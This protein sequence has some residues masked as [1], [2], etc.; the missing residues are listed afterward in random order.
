MKVTSI[1]IST[2]SLAALGSAR[3]LNK[4]R[5]VPTP[6]AFAHTAPTGQAFEL[7]VKT[8]N[9]GLQSYYSRTD[10]FIHVPI[11]HGDTV[12]AATVRSVDDDVTCLIQ[13]VTGQIRKIGGEFPDSYEREG[14]EEQAV[15]IR[16]DFVN[17]PNPADPQPATHVYARTD[18]ANS[19][20][21]E[22]D[23]VYATAGIVDLY[24]YDTG[25][26]S[27]QVDKSDVLLSATI[28]G[29]GAECIITDADHVE[30]KGFGGKYFDSIDLTTYES[31]RACEVNCNII[32][33]T[34]Y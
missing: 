27:S 12:L 25:Y 7:D 15:S 10:G 23:L 18:V 22:V 31:L 2:L 6:T 5:T 16:C 34:S 13:G 11:T 29:E 3:V 32:Q 14:F 21:F 1:A 28:R 4:A 33:E 26:V 24:S 19:T 30:I 20:P 9:L 8:S 17:N